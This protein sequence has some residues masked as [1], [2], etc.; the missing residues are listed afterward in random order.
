MNKELAY[1]SNEKVLNDTNQQ[2]N[3]KISKIPLLGVLI[4]ILAVF[5]FSV[6]LSAV[7]YEETR[8][9]MPGL[10]MVVFLIIGAV[11]GFLIGKVFGSKI[12]FKA[13]VFIESVRKSK[14]SVSDNG[15]N[16]NCFNLRDISKKHK[17]P[18]TVFANV[19]EAEM[20]T[21]S[22]NYNQIN[23]VSIKNYD[24]GKVNYGYTLIINSSGT[25]YALFCMDKDMS[26]NAKN[27]I[28]SNK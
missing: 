16:C 2:I 19:L 24:M 28:I 12:K 7:V 4:G 21:V 9:T 10:V 14:I 8:D 18:F 27:A 6:L 20:L 3:S 1:Y 5:L 15:I 23:S 11:G 26:D 17:S 25:E 22:L 13:T